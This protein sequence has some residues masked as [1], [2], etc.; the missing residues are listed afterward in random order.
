M[1]RLRREDHGVI[2]GIVRLVTIDVVNNFPGSERPTYGLF[3]NDDVLVHVSGPVCPRMF[4]DIKRRPASKKRS[5]TLPGRT[6]LTNTTVGVAQADRFCGWLYAARTVV[7][8]QLAP[9]GLRYGVPNHLLP[10]RCHSR[11]A[12]SHA[13]TVTIDKPMGLPL[14]VAASLIRVDDKRRDTPASAFAK[15]HESDYS[16]G[17]LSF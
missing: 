10:E 7:L 17:V 5:P 12:T 13:G 3:C 11:R 1:F 16:R 8:R 6:S 9:C 4:R 2:R 14:H 15:I